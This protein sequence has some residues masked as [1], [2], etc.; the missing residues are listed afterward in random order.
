MIEQCGQI[1]IQL[2]TIA[3]R[4]RVRVGRSVRARRGGSKMFE[5]ECSR[6]SSRNGGEIENGSESD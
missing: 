6:S 1:L 3:L 4:E 5:V 2:G